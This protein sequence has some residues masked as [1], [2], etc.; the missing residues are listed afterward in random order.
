MDRVMASQV[1]IT[2]VE[3]NSLSAAAETLGLS[4]GMVTRYLTQMEQW[5]GARLLHRTTRRLSLTATG[6]RTLA[7][8]R[9][10]LALAKEIEQDH[11]YHSEELSGALRI[12]CSLSLA[13]GAMAPALH[14]FQQQHPQ[15]YIDMHISNERSHLIKERID[16][17]L[18][19]T[20]ELEPNLIARP[21][22]VCDSVLCASPEWLASHTSP[23][24]PEELQRYNC[25]TYSNFG[26]SIWYFEHDQRT[27]A[28]AVSGN[29]GANDSVFLLSSTLAGAGISMQPL[30][31]VAPLLA[32]GELIELLPTYRPQALGIYGIYSTRQQQLPAL[33]ALIDFL[34]DW[35]AHSSD[36]RQLTL[37]V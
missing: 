35:F 13:C 31:S 33:R 21:L 15:V 26:K 27:T 18:R 25:L 17:A 23:V 29:L 28:V 10:L 2:I 16:L 5:A 3:R 9:D 37:S 20:S 14:L 34:A 24:T 12:S 8:C 19:I 4:R 22:G 36:W 7:R 11:L 1:F 32:A 30:H 6:E